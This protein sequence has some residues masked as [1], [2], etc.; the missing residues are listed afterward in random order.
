MRS[1]SFTFFTRF[2]LT[3]G[4]ALIFGGLVFAAAATNGR[5]AKEH[6]VKIQ[7]MAFVPAK[8]QIAAG[9]KITWVNNDIVMHGAKSSDPKNV[10]QSKDLPPHGSWSKTFTVGGPYV[11]PYHPTMTGEILVTP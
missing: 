9:D 1:I 8:L 11:C 2:A 7:G 3:L 6:I 5:P 4:A 10:W